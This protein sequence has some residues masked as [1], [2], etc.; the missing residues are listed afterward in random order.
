MA[1]VIYVP[2]ST[3]EAA[4]GMA[5]LLWTYWSWLAVT[6]VA[7]CALTQGIKPWYLRRFRAWR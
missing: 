5:K 4:T 1:A 2:F 6:L 3:L 7:Y